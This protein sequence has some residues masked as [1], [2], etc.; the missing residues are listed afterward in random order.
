ME[1]GLSLFDLIFH[2]DAQLKM[3]IHNF[4]IYTY[5]ILFLLIFCETGLV[6]TPFLPGDSLLF[7][8]GSLA[9]AGML[10]IQ[11]LFIGIVFSAVLGN[12]VNYHIGYLIGPKIFDSKKFKLIKREHLIKT[13]EYY[14]RFGMQA[15]IIS[16]FV[17]IVRTIAPFLAG[18]SRMNY[19]CFLG[20]NVVG[21]LLWTTMLLLG[22]YFFGNIPIVQENYAAVIML[23][24]VVSLVPTFI[25]LIRQRK[26]A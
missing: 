1:Q 10:N 13:K 22:G 12:A 5:L 23:I 17:P 14:N 21:A 2:L 16:R 19:P 9:G 26:K 4:G 25:E 3:V 6:V 11:L 15:I 7:I 8:A 24:I 18:I 20:Y